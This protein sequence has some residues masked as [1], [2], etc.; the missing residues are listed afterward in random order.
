MSVPKLLSNRVHFV[1]TKDLAEKY[2]FD[3]IRGLELPTEKQPQ[4]QKALEATFESFMWELRDA[5]EVGLSRGVQETFNLIQDPNYYETVKKRDKNQRERARQQRQQWELESAEQARRKNNPTLDEARQDINRTLR[6]MIYEKDAYRRNRK[7]FTE[8]ERKHGTHFIKEV[9][10]DKFR[11]GASLI[12][13]SDAFD[14][15][16]FIRGLTFSNISDNTESEQVNDSEN[17][18]SF[19]DYK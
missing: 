12:V 6:E 19:F 11:H 7:K 14:V 10:L 13:E 3:F 8:L 9:V 5:L 16:E 15:D 4:I 17:V 18:V 1:S 2:S